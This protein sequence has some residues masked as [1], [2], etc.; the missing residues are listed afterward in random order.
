MSLSTKSEKDLKQISS[1]LE[2]IVEKKDINANVYDI[3]GLQVDKVYTEK[4]SKLQ[5]KLQN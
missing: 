2:D 5:I 4:I 3:I 1:K